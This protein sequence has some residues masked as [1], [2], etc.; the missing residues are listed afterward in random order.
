[1]KVPRLKK[2]HLLLLIPV[3]IVPVTLFLLLPSSPKD[4][5][6][7]L[8]LSTNSPAMSDDSQP[9]AAAPITEAAPVESQ[10]IVNNDLPKPSTIPNQPSPPTVTTVTQI[11]VGDAGDV[12]C[13]YVYSD[14][15]TY[16]WH[17]RT[18][19]QQGSWVTDSSGNNGHWLPSTSES[20][21]CD[22]ST[23]GKVKG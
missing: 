16:Q 17:W 5:H 1:M 13:E 9:A 6:E 12:D 21:T 19:K 14:G 20:G 2:K 11:P 18:V 4:H 15:T 3:V 10:P 7:P 8:P 23:V 22:Q